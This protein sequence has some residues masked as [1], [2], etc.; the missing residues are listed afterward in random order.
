MGL[1]TYLKSKKNEIFLAVA[2]FVL[3]T[4]VIGTILAV[5]QEWIKHTLFDKKTRVEAK[6]AGSSVAA[7]EDANSLNQLQLLSYVVSASDLV[8]NVK[9]SI[10]FAKST[11]IERSTVLY[12][13]DIKGAT[14]N[15]DPA[16][17]LEISLAHPLDVS[18]K[19]YI[20]LLSKRP[21]KGVSELEVEIPDFHVEGTDK[22]GNTVYH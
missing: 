8:K 20:Y 12:S 21:I 19:V 10:T 9:I 13:V 7:F 5:S 3:G 1:R 16:N 6:L 2:G 4:M 18:K 15:K 11:E 22:N 14:Q 17:H